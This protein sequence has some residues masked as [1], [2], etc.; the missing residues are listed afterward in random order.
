[1]C[2][3][4]AGASHGVGRVT[5]RVTDLVTGPPPAA[6]AASTIAVDG[7]PITLRLAID[8]L[9]PEA[10]DLVQDVAA[11]SGGRMTVTPIVNA[12]G[13]DGEEGVARMLEH[14]DAE[15]GLVATRAWDLAGIDSLRAL[16][17]PFLIGD[18]AL[19]VA[20]ATSPV[21]RTALDAMGGVVGLELWPIEL[22]HLMAFESCGKD[23][24]Q[25][26]G[27]KGST[28]MTKPSDTTTALLRVLGA[29][30][31]FK[32]NVDRPAVAFAC[33]AQGIDA[34]FSA[35]GVPMQAKPIAVGDVTMFPKY[36]SLAANKDAFGRLSDPQRTVLRIAA[37]AVRDAAITRYMPDAR[38]GHAWCSLGGTVVLAG[39]G[40]QND[41][42]AATAA[43]TTDL[44]RDPVANELIAGIRELATT[45]TAAPAAAPC[46]RPAQPP[47]VLPAD[48]T[49]YVGDP[50]P[51]GTYRRQLDYDELRAHGV[52]EGQSRGNSP[53]RL[54]LIFDHGRMTL[55]VEHEGLQDVC[56]G[57][58]ESVDGV[59]RQHTTSG[60][61]PC[62]FNGDVVWRPE[63]DGI[64]FVNAPSDFVDPDDRALLDYWVWTRI[65]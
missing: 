3:R 56:E 4:L 47:G 64:S 14:G 5:D 37:V 35:G 53:T 33:E 25:P 41:F 31:W 52:S 65:D 18:D 40:A 20:V 55:I 12:G 8:G 42:R 16:Q 63:P 11:L 1:M 28:I 19:A 7:P 36:V 48:L 38:G 15:L 26:A 24:R 13:L 32:P 21:A 60:P 17:A 49:G 6:S 34:G 46:V 30:P 58:Y 43:V 22:R 44:E 2:R 51:D 27:L 10:G 57:T 29:V 61:D 59:V 23:F 45:T 62:E 9:T 39:D 54:T 50:F